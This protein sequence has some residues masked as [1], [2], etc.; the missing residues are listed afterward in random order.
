MVLRWTS[1]SLDWKSNFRWEENAPKNKNERVEVLIRIRPGVTRLAPS[2][3]AVQRLADLVLTRERAQLTKDAKAVTG[4][5][6]D[7]EER[8]ALFVRILVNDADWNPKPE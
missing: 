1:E 3:G 6:N 5:R 7:W 2:T 4:L 8:K